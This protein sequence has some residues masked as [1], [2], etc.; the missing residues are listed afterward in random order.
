MDVTLFT[1]ERL[2]VH[3]TFGRTGRWLAK[4]LRGVELAEHRPRRGFISISKIERDALG[5]PLR[6][7]VVAF[8]CSLPD[9]R[10]LRWEPRDPL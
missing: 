2:V 1:A 3:E 8:A 9:R 5:D 6:T 7:L 4:A 10:W